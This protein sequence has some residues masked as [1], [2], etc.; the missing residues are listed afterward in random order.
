MGVVACG[1]GLDYALFLAIYI[2]SYTAGLVA[3]VPGGLGVF[4]GTMLLAL[5]LVACLAN[6]GRYFRIPAVLLHRSTVSRRWH[7]CR[8]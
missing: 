3:S 7:V 4:D 5:T 8:A 2:A 1:C 6:S